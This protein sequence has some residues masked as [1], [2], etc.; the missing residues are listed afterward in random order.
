MARTEFIY[1]S[2]FEDLQEKL[3]EEIVE[4]VKDWGIMGEDVSDAVDYFIKRINNEGL[5]G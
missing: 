2:K 5:E 4:F 1:D 3:R